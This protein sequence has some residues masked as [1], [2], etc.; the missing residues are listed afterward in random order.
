MHNT[1]H[2]RCFQAESDAAA[3]LTGRHT[4]ANT[5]G[6][7]LPYRQLGC[8]RARERSTVRE[9][10]RRGRVEERRQFSKDVVVIKLVNW[11]AVS[12]L[13]INLTHF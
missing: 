9:K 3:T 10:E 8:E 6:V 2:R 4:W 12:V 5:S 1:P 7:Y 13:E 11:E